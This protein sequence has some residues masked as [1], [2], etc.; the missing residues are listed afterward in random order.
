MLVLGTSIHE[1][2]AQPSWSAK[3][4]HPRIEKKTWMLGTSPSMTIVEY[5]SVLP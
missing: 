3:A 1:L 2:T 4:V 5:V